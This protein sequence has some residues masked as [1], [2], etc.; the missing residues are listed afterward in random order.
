MYLLHVPKYVVSHTF[1]WYL[2]FKIDFDGKTVEQI[3]NNGLK[4]TQ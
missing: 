1:Y 3:Q 4:S 2:K